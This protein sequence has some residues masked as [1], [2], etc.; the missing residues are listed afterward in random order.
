MRGLS[1]VD[2]KIDLLLLGDDRVRCPTEPAARVLQHV[3]LLQWQVWLKERVLT[4]QVQRQ[5]YISHHALRVR[6]LQ[7][8]RPGQLRRTACKRRRTTIVKVL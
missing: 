1:Y 3:E 8:C 7:L 4:E 6:R 5:P 2:E